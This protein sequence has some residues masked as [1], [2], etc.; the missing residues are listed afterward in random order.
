VARK[1]LAAGKAG[2]TPVLCVG[3]S[4]QERR[5]GVTHGVLARQLQAVVDVV[6]A[7]AFADAVVVYEP[8]WAIGAGMTASP[9]QAQEVH[10][11]IRRSVAQTDPEAA[12]SLHI[13]YGGPLKRATTRALL[14][15]PDIDGG[16]LEGASLNVDE[17]L[18]VALTAQ[19]LRPGGVP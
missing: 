14:A 6:G 8:V 13:L 9:E 5:Q 12:A 16:L 11:F 15:M 19:R 4:L 3:E 2:L 1:F 7:G 17:L 18:A 10:A